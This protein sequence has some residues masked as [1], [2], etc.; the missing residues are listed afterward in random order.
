M[1]E[2]LNCSPLVG[3]RFEILRCLVYKIKGKN[4]GNIHGTGQY[5]HNIPFFIVEHLQ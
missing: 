5:L 1:W 4:K 3:T 2:D